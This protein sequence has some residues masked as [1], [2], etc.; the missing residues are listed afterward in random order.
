[1]ENPVIEE[2]GVIVWREGAF[3]EGV[4]GISKGDSADDCIVFQ[5]GSGTYSFRLADSV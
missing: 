2:S 3:A 5:V 1:M 4:P